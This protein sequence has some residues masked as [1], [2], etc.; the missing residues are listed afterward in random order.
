MKR[1]SQRPETKNSGRKRAG[2]VKN[3][4]KAV[5]KAPET[6]AAIV[7]PYEPPA[8]T[9]HV[10]IRTKFYGNDKETV[11]TIPIPMVDKDMI[12]LDMT[13]DLRKSEYI[14]IRPIRR[15]LEDVAGVIADAESLANEV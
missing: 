9:V 8:K 11:Q 3:A 12:R 7:R 10:Q 14:E 13:I 5:P 6:P 1:K 2:R 15:N 4:V